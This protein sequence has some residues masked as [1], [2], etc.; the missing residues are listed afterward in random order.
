MRNPLV[1]PK[2]QVYITASQG[3][4]ARELLGW[5][6]ADLSFHA[7]VYIEFVKKL[8]GDEWVSAII[9]KRIR[10]AFQARKVVFRLEEAPYII[11]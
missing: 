1:A 2:S 8:E 10:Q 7:G 9:L 3:R 5:T 4:L 6:Q 11:G